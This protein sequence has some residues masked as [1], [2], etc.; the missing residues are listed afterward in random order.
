M[1]FLVGPTIGSLF[2]KLESKPLCTEGLCGFNK[3][4]SKE[5]HNFILHSNWEVNSYM[6]NTREFCERDYQCTMV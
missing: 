2:T 5:W 1:Q 6:N 4:K 3:Y